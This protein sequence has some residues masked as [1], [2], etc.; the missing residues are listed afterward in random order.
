MLGAP[1]EKDAAA[2]LGGELALLGAR[3]PGSASRSGIRSAGASSALRTRSARASAPFRSPR[4]DGSQPR[5]DDDHVVWEVE[6]GRELATIAVGENEPKDLAFSSDGR[7]LTSTHW[8]GSRATVRE[9][10]ARTGKPLPARPD[11]GRPFVAA[12]YRT[13]VTLVDVESGAQHPL[14]E[15]AD[16]SPPTASFFLGG[17][18]LAMSLQE[19]GMPYVSIRDTQDGRE[20]ARLHPAGQGGEIVF[21]PDGRLLVTENSAEI[22]DLAGGRPPMRL[23]P[24]PNPIAAVSHRT[25]AGC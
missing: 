8:D 25:A 22:W 10:D 6:T 9:W 24:G 16:S 12:T 14:V 15:T 23:H 7:R 5:D 2:V 13:S 17:R 11:A 3:D 20:V 18:R 4:T 21:S 19:R 1:T